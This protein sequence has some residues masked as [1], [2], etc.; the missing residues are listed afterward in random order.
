MSTI[1]GSTSRVQKNK[2]LAKWLRKCEP[3]QQQ[4]RKSFSNA[5]NMFVNWH[6]PGKLTQDG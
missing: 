5:L 6:L 4:Q 2:K 3:L 1:S